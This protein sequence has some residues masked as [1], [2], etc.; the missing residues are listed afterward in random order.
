M[1]KS[2]TKTVKL[3]TCLLAYTF[4]SCISK[5]ATKIVKGKKI[6]KKSTKKK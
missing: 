4:S 6:K 3:P 1:P 5:C 2:T